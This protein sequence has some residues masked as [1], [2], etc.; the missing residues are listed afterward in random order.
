MKMRSEGTPLKK[1]RERL[2]TL[3]LR[4]PI[5]ERVELDVAMG[6]AEG[7]TLETIVAALRPLAAQG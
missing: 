6:A 1:F 3:P 2:P 7:R 5:N 4:L